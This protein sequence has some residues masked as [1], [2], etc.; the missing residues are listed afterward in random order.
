D[1]LL[2]RINKERTNS[3]LVV[4]GHQGEPGSVLDRLV[5]GKLPFHFRPDD[6]VIFASK[7]IPTPINILNKEQILK[8]LKKD[9]VRIFDNVH[10]SGHA[11]KEDIKDLLTIIKPKNI[12]P[13]HGTTEQLLPMIEIAKEVGY[14]TGKECHLMHDGHKIRL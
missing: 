8:R 10:V 2:T 14:R 1:S 6:H 12:I 5:K 3:V 13:A 11:G 7:T 4:T 9:R